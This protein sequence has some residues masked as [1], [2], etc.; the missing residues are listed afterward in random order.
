MAEES[1]IDSLVEKCVEVN[2]T[3]EKSVCP[4]SSKLWEHFMLKP[5]KKTV[6]CKMCSVDLAWHGS[7]T[8]R[9]EHLK[10][11]HVGARDEGNSQYVTLKIHSSIV[12]LIFC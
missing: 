3:T 6:S 2:D 9:W 10:R 4:K 8:S 7:G 1:S 11:K 5:S 12:F